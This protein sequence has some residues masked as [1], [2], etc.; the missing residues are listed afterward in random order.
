MTL[1]DEEGRFNLLFSPPF[2]EIKSNAQY[3]AFEGQFVIDLFR[4]KGS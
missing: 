3:T 4:L 2:Y 1:E